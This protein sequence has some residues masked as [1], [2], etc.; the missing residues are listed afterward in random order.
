MNSNL[1]LPPD[2][3]VKVL[4]YEVPPRA[5]EVPLISAVVNPRMTS[6]CKNYQF[7]SA[8]ARAAPRQYCRKCKKNLGENLR[9]R[10]QRISPG[11]WATSF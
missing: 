2:P 11:F 9:D 10:L 1:T 8:A 6:E 4:Y 5:H 7:F 3:N